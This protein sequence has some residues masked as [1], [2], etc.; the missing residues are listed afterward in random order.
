MSDVADDAILRLFAFIAGRVCSERRSD[1]QSSQ[2]YGPPAAKV[3]R[4]EDGAAPPPSLQQLQRDL[5][6]AEK[7]KVELEKELLREKIE[8]VK[9]KRALV[10]ARSLQ[11]DALS[12]AY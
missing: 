12:N 1:S 10:Q 4:M 11:L 8:L 7:E 5:L 3:P 9:E 2:P 6:T